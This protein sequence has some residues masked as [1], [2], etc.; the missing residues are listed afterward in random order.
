MGVISLPATC[1]RFRFRFI[2]PR[3]SSAPP[4]VLF[5][6]AGFVRSADESDPDRSGVSPSARLFSWTAIPQRYVSVLLPTLSLLIP[7][8][9]P[10]HRNAP[11]NGRTTPLA[12]PPSPLPPSQHTSRRP[13]LIRTC[14]CTLSSRRFRGTC[15]SRGLPRW[16]GQSCPGSP[17]GRGVRPARRMGRG[18]GGW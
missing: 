1:V 13:R 5:C 9:P 7:P 6:F 4:F 14:T 16:V 2:S 10:S 15:M 18:G 8:P 17:R 3:P 11:T 12:S